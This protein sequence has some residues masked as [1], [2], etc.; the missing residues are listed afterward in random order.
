MSSTQ[1][2]PHWVSYEPGKEGVERKRPHV[3]SKPIGGLDDR[4]RAGIGAHMMFPNVLFA[5]ESEFFMSYVP[6]P[7]AADKCFVD[8]RIRAEIGADAE[9]LVAAAKDF[10]LEDIAACEAIQS[11]VGSSRFRVGALAQQHELPIT[12]YHEHLLEYVNY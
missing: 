4:D 8:V 7:V 1:I 10:M 6:T 3:G 11:V 12:N 9:M 5:T 2:G